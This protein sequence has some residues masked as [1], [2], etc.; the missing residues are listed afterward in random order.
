MPT[1]YESWYATGI[2]VK[3]RIVTN[4]CLNPL[5]SGDS[6][7]MLANRMSVVVRAWACAAIFC[8]ATVSASAHPFPDVHLG[9][10]PAPAATAPI[11]TVA[12]TV[13]EL[14]ID[15]RV[16]GQTT[17]QVALLLDDGHTVALNG[18]GLDA[19]TQ[20]QRVQA[21]GQLSGDTLFLTAYH[22]VAGGAALAKVAP[23]VEGTLAMVHADNFDQGRSSYSYVVR[24]DDGSTT[25][26]QLGVMPDSLQIGMRVV[27]A[28]TT[29][30]DG[31]SIDADHITVL[32][33]APPKTADDI[34][35]AP[36]TNNLLVVLVKF[37]GQAEAFT[38][39]QV[40]QIM[41][42]NG[43][44]VANYYQEASYGQQLLNVTVTPWLLSATAGPATC[45]YTT[46]GNAGDAAAAAAGYNPSSYQN[47]FYV[48]PSRADCGWAGLAYVGFPRLAWS[49][50]Y[51]QLNVYGHELGHNF[52]LLH[53]ASLYCPGQ[54][55]GGSCSVSEY[56]DPFDVMGNISAMH[57]NSTQKSILNWLPS[58]SVKT[59][60]GGSATYTLSPLES[61]GGATYAVK[62][63]AAANR[64]YW[65]EFR[66]PI[67][68]D[69]GLSSYP[70]NGAQ[71]RV[72]SP[73]ATLCSGCADDTELLDMTPATGGWFGDAALLAGQSYTDV[74]NNITMSVLSASPTALSL[75]IS[76][77]GSSASLTASPS[78]V[79]IGGTL[80]AS[81]SGITVPSSTDW[82]G[83]FVPG[84]PATSSIAWIYVS[85]T[86]TPGLSLAAGSCPF[87]I[88]NIAPRTYEL[89]LFSNDSHT[90]LAISNT[91]AV[92]A[93]QATSLTAS[94]TSIGVGAALTATWSAIATPTSTDWVGL[95][96][97]GAPATASIAWIYV[98]CTQIPGASLAT[99]SCPFTIPNVPLGIYELRL[100]SNDSHTTLAIS[101][102]FAVTA[103]QATSLTASP[104]SIGVG[105]TLTA[106]WSGIATPSSTD[107]V[108]L[109]VPGAP[110]TNS[111]AW[112]YVSC[113]QIP[114]VSLA[115][116]SC[117]FTIPNVAPGTYELR[118]FTN[119]SHTTLATSNAFAVTPF[120]PTTLTASPA[121]IGV[122]G[123]LNASW[124]GIA[125]PSSTDWVGLF[126]PGA[127]ATNSIAWIYVNCTQTP[128]ASFAAGSCP[129]RIPNI[130]LGTYELRLF[131]N[132]SHTTLASSNTFAVTAP[133]SLAA[134]P[135][136]IRTGGT[137][138][139][140]WSGIS[141]PSSTDWVGLFV[142]GAP[143][144]SSITWIYVNCTQTP[145]ASFT[146]GSCPFRT[147]NVA[148]G[149]YEL[150]LFSN[151]SHT[152]L[153]TSNTVIVT[154]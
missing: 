124:S 90:T 106:S 10:A 143:A 82:V 114:G 64:T 69:A 145:G 68:F 84:A 77:A 39:A 119:D 113:T 57:F 111:I 44:S 108:G 35:P 152:T 33:A 4:G 58:G 95:F 51:N 50:G 67:G 117:P 130:A 60:A 22:A 101:N 5:Y 100:F 36:I 54:V 129:F 122:G 19:L 86:Q 135:S 45:D 24:G 56:G 29:A 21:N 87:R 70:N 116:G 102:T 37:P 38:Q 98:S 123:T 118:L 13:K 63:P 42:T 2:R 121:S 65:I 141:I 74:A 66:Q 128:G 76:G 1:A 48:F 71:V 8:V 96:V 17:R 40:D 83:L 47:R 85:C 134:S 30:S 112:I 131:S 31:F 126:V 12:G 109:F 55:I 49:N 25:P 53:A 148:P 138:T 81:W 137:L 146:A 99:G 153:A 20:N 140:S 115:S 94:P 18:K 144:T 104:A 43:N 88:P 61:P 80:T 139:A 46:I 78:S 23:Q 107:W 26:L 125:T 136:S 28:G 92:T 72:A 41:R 97:P 7:I 15:N 154:P 34:S 52:G 132:D 62:V 110:A 16:T 6:N 75:Q 32:I 103:A 73:F 91:F 3:T 27:A 150:R 133:P 9:V 14:V 151:D 59:Y 147:P 89:R 105:G 120:Q 149:T 127:P 93:A 11:E 79:G 142:R